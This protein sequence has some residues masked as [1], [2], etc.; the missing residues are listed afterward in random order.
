[1]N[2]LLSIVSHPDTSGYDFTDYDD[3]ACAGNG[4][5]DDDDDDDDDD[6]E[7]KADTMACLP[8]TGMTQER[9]FPRSISNLH[10]VLTF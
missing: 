4:D 2:E 8:Q 3:C 10:S 1:M 7:Y 6:D 9:D 5:H